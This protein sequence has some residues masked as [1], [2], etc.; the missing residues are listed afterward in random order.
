MRDPDGVRQQLIQGGD[1]RDRSTPSGG[2]SE[3]TATA[4]SRRS[5]GTARTTSCTCAPP[6]RLATTTTTSR[7]VRRRMRGRD[8]QTY[9]VSF[10]ARWLSGSNQLN[11]RAYYSRLARTTES[12]HASA[13]RHA[14]RCRIPA[15]SPIPGRRC[16][17]LAHSP[18]LP[19]PSEPVT[20]R[21]TATDPGQCDARHSALRARWAARTLPR[22]PWQNWRRTLLRERSRHKLRAP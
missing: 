2:C 13:D 11:T 5:R 7:H 19:A 18:V 17:S 1:F 3:T 16:R 14:R 8:G 6:G 12:D 21:V 4:R 10:R 15:S 20:V 22:C 9:E